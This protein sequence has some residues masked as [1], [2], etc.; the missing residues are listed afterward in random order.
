MEKKFK[1]RNTGDIGY[2]K[3]GV[4]KQGRC[5]V[6]IGHE[7]SSKVWEDITEEYEILS[8]FH[9][10]MGLF[11]KDPQ[12]HYQITPTRGGGFAVV[13]DYALAFSEEYSIFSVKRLSDDV[14]L[15]V[16]DLID[17]GDRET[18]KIERFESKGDNNFWAFTNY[19][20]GYGANINYI[21]KVKELLFVTED[22]VDIFKGDRVWVVSK[23]LSLASS[24]PNGEIFFGDKYFAKQENAEKYIEENKKM[25][26]LKDM[27]KMANHWAYVKGQP[28]TENCLKIIEK[29]KI[30][31][32]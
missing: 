20:E 6:D 21:E 30:K 7:P 5:C 28:T 13:L 14:V 12:G 31:H 4:F 11:Y 17:L 25:Y 26:S 32:T 9:K 8:L 2:Y 3:D 15:T 1:N 10:E 29:W 23:H 18:N 24:E 16:G 22:G 27:V 19:K